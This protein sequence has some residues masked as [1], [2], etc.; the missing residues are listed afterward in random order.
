VAGGVKET[1]VEWGD[2]GQGMG[3]EEK[4]KGEGVEEVVQAM[5]GE[6]GGGREGEGEEMAVPCDYC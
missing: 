3:V 2:W 6:E 1:V 5:V 4:G